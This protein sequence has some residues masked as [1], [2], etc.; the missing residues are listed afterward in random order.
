MKCILQRTGEV[1]AAEVEKADRFFARLKGL[2]FRKGL[3]PQGALLLKPCPQIHTCFMRFDLDVIFC[4]QA[5]EILCIIE[6][7]R[8]WRMS[9]FVRGASWTLE[10]TGGSL[11]G[12]LKVGDKLILQ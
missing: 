3:P 5:G 7:M 11:Q 6:Q 1:V 10:L 12:R 8:P 2:M 4:N 9:K